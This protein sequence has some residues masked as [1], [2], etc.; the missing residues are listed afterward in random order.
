M[1]FEAVLTEMGGQIGLW[2][3]WSFITAFEFIG[4]G[5]VLCTLCCM[6]KPVTPVTVG[7][8]NKQLS[9]QD[10][11]MAQIQGKKVKPKRASKSSRPHGWAPQTGYDFEEI[12]GPRLP[13]TIEGNSK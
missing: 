1:Q 2:L 11:L 12:V 6:E 8:D 7:N 9:I 4:L 10:R 5:F 3:G 13:Q